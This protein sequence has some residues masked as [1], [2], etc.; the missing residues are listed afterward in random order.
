M[1][2]NGILDHTYFNNQKGSII[3]GQ[4]FEIR[5]IVLM[6]VSA[7]VLFVKLKLEKKI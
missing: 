6:S 3:I 1:F 7:K 5:A 4:N 2:F